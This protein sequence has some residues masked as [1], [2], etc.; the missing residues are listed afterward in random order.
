MKDVY[1][2]EMTLRNTEKN[3]LGS[4]FINNDEC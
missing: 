4:T 1:I 2:Y 3:V